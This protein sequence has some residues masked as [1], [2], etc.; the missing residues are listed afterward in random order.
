MKAFFFGFKGICININE[1]EHKQHPVR[2]STWN[3]QA[4]RMAPYKK[5]PKQS[6]K[7]SKHRPPAASQT[8]CFSLP[9]TKASSANLYEFFHQR[10]T[11][12]FCQGMFRGSM[13]LLPSLT[14]GHSLLPMREATRQQPQ[15][16]STCC[17]E[18]QAYSHG[19]HW[20]W[21]KA[22]EKLQDL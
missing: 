19:W 4:L 8:S 3:Y 16:R 9:G 14:D 5:T 6:A 12:H 13:L 2:F 17:W 7:I 18:E 22:P 20:S 15:C 10:G 1:P 11:L 21:L